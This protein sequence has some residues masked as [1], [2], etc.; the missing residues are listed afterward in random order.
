MRNSHDLVGCIDTLFLIMPLSVLFLI[1][2][3]HSVSDCFQTGYVLNGQLKW[4]GAIS[5][6]CPNGPPKGAE[7]FHVKLTVSTA[8]PSNEVKLY[9]KGALVRSWNPHFPVKSLGGVLVANG[10]KNV[11]QFREFKIDTPSYVSK[12]CVDTVQYPAY[13]KL[14]ADHG[15]WPGDRFCQVAYLK[16]GGQTTDYQL[17]VDL[18]NVKGWQGV[19]SGHLGVLY[20]AVDQE[21]YDFVYFRFEKY[22]FFSFSVLQTQALCSIE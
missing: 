7:W 13:V 3:P 18:F 6:T 5:S 2:R 14:D 9:L 8:S 22:L 1:F 11:I 16:D 20:N 17:S 15:T 19:N 4:D 12:R 10:Y 21:N